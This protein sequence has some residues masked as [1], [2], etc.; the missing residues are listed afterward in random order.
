MNAESGAAALF[1]ACQYIAFCC[2]TLFTLSWYRCIDNTLLY[3]VN[4]LMGRRG[5]LQGYAGYQI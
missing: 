2:V 3:R 4:G 5:T 1:T